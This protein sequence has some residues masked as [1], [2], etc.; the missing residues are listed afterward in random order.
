L[1]LLARSR[2]VADGEDAYAL[3]RAGMALL[4]SRKHAALT[5]AAPAM[6]RGSRYL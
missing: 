1:G 5:A 6:R 3:T 2:G 4:V